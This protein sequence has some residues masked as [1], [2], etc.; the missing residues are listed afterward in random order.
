[1]GAV[2]GHHRCVGGHAVRRPRCDAQVPN[3]NPTVAAPGAE[4]TGVLGVPYH[5]LYGARVPA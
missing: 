1:M 2:D 3:A 4:Q 5:R